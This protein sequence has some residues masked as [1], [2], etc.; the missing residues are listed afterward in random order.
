M[1][2]RNKTKV[3]QVY[4]EIFEWIDSHR[5]KELKMEKFYLNFIQKYTQPEANILDVGCGTGE[6]IARF[7]LE[8]GYKLTGVDASKKMIE[9]CK[10]RFPDGKWL[11]AD[12]RTLDLQEQFDAVIAW[13]SFFHLPHD[14]QRVTLKLLATFVSQ[15]GLLIFTTG[16]EY[17]EV[18][19]DNGGHDLYHASLSSEEYEQILTDNDFKVLTHKIR[20]PE[21]GDATV[22]VAQKY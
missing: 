3:Y 22:W 9:V 13:H 18:W 8:K 16:P 6:P 14:D 20:D 15:K 4:D 11:L 17:G 5:N 12:M 1:A 21:C 7:L 10:K 19:S 2:E